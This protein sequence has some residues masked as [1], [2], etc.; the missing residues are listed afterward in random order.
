MIHR[1][2]F[3]DSTLL[4]LRKTLLAL[5]ACILLFS[6]VSI[7]PGS[8]AGEPAPALLERKLELLA[9]EDPEACIE[10]VADLLE[11][12]RAGGAA[13][14]ILGRERLLEILK[15]SAQSLESKLESAVATE[16]YAMARRYAVSAHALVL[17][18]ESGALSLS[19]LP[20]SF[21]AWVDP[22]VQI[23]LLLGQAEQIYRK[24]GYAAGKALI[25]SAAAVP[26][27]LIGAWIESDAPESPSVLVSDEL[28]PK[29]A[30]RTWVQRAR[31]NGDEDAA[32]WFEFLSKKQKPPVPQASGDSQKWLS[33]AIGSV[34][35]VY[36]DRGFRISGGYSIPDRVVGTAFQIAPGLY[37]TNHHVIQSEVDPEYEGY[38]KLSIRPSENPAIRVPGKVVGWDEEMDLALIKSEEKPGNVIH[39]PISISLESGERVYAAGSPVGLENS[40]NAGIVSSISRKI[41][42]FGEAVQIDVPVNQ[43]NSGSPLFLSSGR[44]AGIV[45]AGLP[46][47]Q[48]INFALPSTWINAVLPDL[49]AEGKTVHRRLGI[50]LGKGSGQNPVVLA[51]IGNSRNRLVPGDA[52]MTLQGVSIKDISAAQ[53][54]LSAIPAD[55]LC[56]VGAERDFHSIVRLRRL[57]HNR[58][59]SLIEI[60]DS[61]DRQIILE[62]LMGFRLISLDQNRNAL[63]RYK[64]AWVCPAEIADESG[65]AENDVVTITKLRPDRKAKEFILEFSVNSLRSGYFERTIR[66]QMPG[67]SD[68]MI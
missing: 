54:M 22:E 24:S 64:V 3:I 43:G 61:A 51:D 28:S 57:S 2:G 32:I 25:A 23:R 58:G 59:P 10:Q 63:G 37:L 40:I 5:A 1:Q 68:T 33:A 20:R 62:A 36:V 29:N 27:S 49:M 19:V 13:A 65:I 35:T 31:E 7:D 21:T 15:K 48:N 26:G 52:L 53:L 30:C 50:V 17:F 38:S 34:V 18:A 46:N 45:F 47:F 12:D 6:C 4:Q 42:S 11:T 55:A 39:V 8:K 44:L 60:W 14:S 66:L 56:I 16:N 67:L 41:I 9:E